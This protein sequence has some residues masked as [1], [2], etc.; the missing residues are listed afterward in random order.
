LI[1][2]HFN[3]FPAGEEPVGVEVAHGQLG[4][5]VGTVEEEDVMKR[6]V[7]RMQRR[8]PLQGEATPGR[9]VSCPDTR[10]A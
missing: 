3:N 8:D 2:S 7:T 10:S 5:L 9:S 4:P 6:Q 1:V